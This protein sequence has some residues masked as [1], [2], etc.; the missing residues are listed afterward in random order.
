MKIKLNGSI[1]IL[2]GRGLLVL[3]RVFMGLQY[4]L[5]ALEE[6]QLTMS[7]TCLQGPD[8]LTGIRYSGRGDM[9]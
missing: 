6:S 1:R 3:L 4:V 2:I 7:T 8:Q 5:S 9:Y